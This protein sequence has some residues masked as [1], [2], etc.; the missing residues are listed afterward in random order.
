MGKN[1]LVAAND[2]VICKIVEEY[3]Q[4]QFGNILIPDMGKEKPEIAEV[5]SVG[6][7]FYTI[8]G[9]LIKTTLIPGDLIMVP[10]FGAQMISF[11]GQ[12]FLITKEIDI[13]AKIESYE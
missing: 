1:R 3:S 7:G 11:E 9:E 12:E 6:P 4:K 5:V 10:K 2:K 8:T 13:I